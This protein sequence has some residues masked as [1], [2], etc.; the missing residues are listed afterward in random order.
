MESPSQIHPVQYVHGILAGSGFA[1]LLTML[2]LSSL[3]CFDRIAVGCV[4]FSLP[5]NAFVC[6]LAEAQDL[7]RN[8]LGFGYCL[9]IYPGRF[10]GLAALFFTFAHFGLYFGFLFLVP[11]VLSYL[12]L[13]SIG[14][15]RLRVL[16]SQ[17]SKPD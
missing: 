5:I 9:L 13:R 14:A 8:W 17:K 7:P 4:A 10:V 12:L 2:T 15:F 16:K 6:F 11:A 1:I 3:S